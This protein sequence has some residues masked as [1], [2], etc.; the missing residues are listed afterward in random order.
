LPRSISNSVGGKKQKEEQMKI[1]MEN[2]RSYLEADKLAEAPSRTARA[3]DKVKNLRDLFGKGWDK[4]DDKLK[5]DY[6]TKTVPSTL[7]SSGDVKTFGELH[8]LLKCTLEY[9]NRKKVLGILTNFVPG[10]AAAKE[11]FSNSD[12]VSEFV[13]GM[14]QVPDGQR[15]QGNL[16]KLDMDD[17]VSEIISDKIEKAFVRWLVSTMQDEGNFERDIPD[18]WDVTDQLRDF[19]KNQNDGRTVTGYEG[20]D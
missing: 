4:A 7:Q 17:S 15:P 20:E 10:V 9:K 5:D 13:L 16:G 12:E 2:W 11:I 14:Y 18:D 3:L 6:C 19:L 1:L 8:A